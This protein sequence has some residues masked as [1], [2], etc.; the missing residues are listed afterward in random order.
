M[1]YSKLEEKIYNEGERLIPGVTHDIME[2]I[3]HRSSYVFFK[4]V[5]ELDIKSGDVSIP[6]RIVDLGC[7]VGHGCYT[8]SEIPNSQILGIDIS[9]ESLKYGDAHYA[10]SNITYQVTDIREFVIQGH[11]F[12]YV[13][14]RHA[15]EHIDDGLQLALS[16]IYRN[17]VMFEV[18]FNEPEGN[19]HHVLMS[20]REEDFSSFPEAELFFQDLGGI[21]YNIQKK[22]LKPNGIICIHGRAKLPKITG[23]KIVFPLKAWEPDEFESRQLFRYY[24]ATYDEHQQLK[25]EHQQLKQTR[26]VIL[27]RKLEEYPLLKKLISMGYDVLAKPYTRLKRRE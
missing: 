12:D 25:D 23:N 6:I 11:E 8:L 3:R 13:I 21:I 24:K 2:L 17:R 5:I 10:K 16:T 18:P 1:D 14:S 9:P 20:I 26:A 22:P 4:K 7:G 27:A 15:F 19:P